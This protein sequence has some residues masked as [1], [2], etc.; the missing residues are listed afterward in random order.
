M[1]RR[2]YL[3]AVLLLSFTSVSVATFVAIQKTKP[4]T[5]AG[6]K[7]SDKTAKGAPAKGSAQSK[8]AAPATPIRPVDPNRAPQAS[9]DDALFTNEDFFGT[10]ASVARPYAVALERIGT[11]E[12]QYPK[13]ARLR[14]HSARLAEH[15]GQFDKAAVA[16]NQYADLKRRSPDSLRRLAHFYHNRAMHPEEVTALTELARA[17]P[18]TER[19][20][21][22]KQAAGLVR[23]Y[24][25]K[26]FK[27]A[28]FFAELVAADSSNLQPVKDYVQE[29]RLAQQGNDALAVLTQY[30]AKFPSDSG[31]FLKTRA[32]I[33]EDRGDRRAAEEVYSAA[34]DPNWSRKIS[35]DY[36]EL[37]RRFGRYRIA[38]RA[39]QDRV[40][41]GA[42]DLQTIARL[43]GFLAYEGN[44][45]QA[46]QVLKDLEA[47]RAG[48]TPANTSSGTTP[49][50]IRAA[51]WTGEELQQTAGMFASIGHFDQAS[52]YL[53]TLYLLGKL[54][55]ATA[56]REDALYRLFKVMIDAAGTPTR[57]G[58][59]D[60]SFYKDIAEIDRHPGFMNGVLSLILSNTSPAD[61]FATQEQAAAGYFNRAFAYRIFT[62]F[63]QEFAQSKYLGEMYL[64]VVS[65]FATMGEHKLAIEAGRE[66]QQKFLAS[67][68][69]V[70]V[71]LSIADSYVAL[72]D[73][74]NERAT[75]L[76]L[77]DR[78]AKSRPRG[79]ALIPSS[80]KRWAYII[81]PTI[82]TIFDKIKY[83]LEAYSDTYEP[84]S[85]KT[86]NSDDSESS[87][88]DEEYGSD[89]SSSTE[90][91]GATYSS[92]LERYVSS[93]A[94]DDKQ[95]ET[96]AFFWNE[97]RKY[98]KE[99][100]LYERFLRWL[101]QAQLINEQ[102]KAY[103]SAIR[104]FDSNTWY[105]RL[106]RWYV[107][108]K[109][110]RELQRYAR[111]LI[112][113]FDEEEIS[114]YLYR[115]GGYGATAAGDELNWDQKLAFDLYDYAHKRFPRNLFFVRGK[116]TYLWSAKSYAEWA[117]L[118]QQYYFA[119]RSIRDPYLAWLSKENQLRDKYQQARN[120]KGTDSSQSGT[121]TTPKN[122]AY[123]TFAADGALWLSHHDEAL[124][125]YRALN[126]FYPGEV[127]YG[128]RLADLTRSFGQTSDKLYEES[129]KA[130]ENLAAVYPANH[131]YRIKAGEVYAQLSD[132]KRAGQQW[133][134][135]T[136]LEPGERETYLEVA[137]VYWDYYQFDE[138]L[139]VFRELRTATGEPNLYAYRMG[140][141]Y[142]NKGDYD[143]AIAEYV[144]VLNEPGD[145]R[146]TVARRLSQ[147]ARR[148]GIEPKIVAAYNR[149]QTADQKDWQLA[150]GYATYLAE[151][152]RQADALA[153]IRSEVARS[154]D[155][156][157]LE[158]VRDLFRAILRPEDEQQVISR[159]SSAARDEREVMMYRL[160][161]ASFLERQG[162]VDDAL[163]IVDK[164]VSDYP[165]NVGVV[166][167]SAKFYW[168]AGVVD[169]ALDLYKR[170]LARAQ[171]ANRRTITL[172]LARRQFD[173]NRLNDAETTLRGYYDENRLDTEA[174]S[175][176]AKVL[177]AANKLDALTEL[178]K[179]ALK[180]VREAGGEDT[181]DRIAELRVG[182]I[183]TFDKLKRYED[184]VDQHIEIINLF[185]ENES[186]LATA[187]DYA[188]KH[189]L[190]PRLTAYYEKLTKEAFKNYRWQLVLAR[191]YERQGNIA[192]ASEQYKNAVANDPSRPEFRRSL[193]STLARQKRYD[194][195]IAVLRDG[196]NLSGRDPE[197]LIEV[198]Q[199]QISQGKR[200]DAVL[201][202]RQALT[203]R[204]NPTTDDDFKM[205][206]KLA[207]WGLHDEAVRV[208]EQTFARVPKVLK[209]EY[210]NGE[211]VRGYARSL[212]RIEPAGR[213]FQKLERMHE[214]YQ[215]IK[216][217]SKDND[218]Y[219]ANAIVENL[220]AALRADFGEGVIEYSRTEDI[221]ALV[222]A[223]QTATAKL[224]TYADKEE[225]LRYVGIAHGA[226]LIQLEEQLLT[227]IKDYA[228]K[229]R[230]K[231]EDMKC[232]EELRALIAF[233]NRRAQFAKAA[234]VLMAQMAEDKF[235]ARFDYQNQIALEYQLTGD[236][237]KELA[238]L[239]AAYAAASGALLE[240]SEVDWVER[241]FTLLVETNNRDELQRVASSFNPHQL[242]LVN[243]LIEKNDKDLA[244]TAIA[245]ASQSP[246]W[247]ASRSGEVGFFLK[248]TNPATEAYFKAAL[249]LRPIGQMLNR[250]LDATQ[251]LLGNDWFVAARNYG[252]WLSVA[253]RDSDSRKLAPAEIEG[254]PRSE[255]AQLE[256]AAYYLDRKDTRRAMNHLQIAAELKP[257]DNDVA[258][259]R[260]MVL[261]AQGDRPGALSAWAAMMSGRVTSDDA[262]AYL[263]VTAGNGFL[264]EGLPLLEDFIISFVNRPLRRGN[265]SD[266]IETIKP[267]IREI[268]NRANA[269]TQNAVAA[270]FSKIMNNTPNDMDIGLL[271]IDERLL[272]ESQLLPVYRAIHQKY[273]DA[274][275]ATFGTP[276]YEDGTTFNNSYIYPARDLSEWRRKFLDYLIRVSNLSE[277]RL[278]ITSIRREEKEA[279]VALESQSGDEESEP[280]D[281]YEWLPLAS[282]LVELRSGRNVAAAVKELREYCHLE[283]DNSST[284]SE[285]DEYSTASNTGIPQHCLKA[286]ALLVAEKRDAE[287]E[288]LLYDAYRKAS[289]T[290]DASDASLAGLAEIEARRGRTAEASR[291]LRKIVERSTDNQR[292]LRLAAETAAKIGRFEEA[293]EFRQQ[294]ARV[295]PDDAANQVEL[296]RALSVSGNNVEAVNLTIKL[297]SD[298]RTP[299]SAKAQLAEM[300]A[301]ITRADRVAGEKILGLFGGAAIQMEGGALLARAAFEENTGNLDAARTTLERVRGSL[302]PV[303]RLKL[304]VL[305]RNT[306]R[307]AEAISNFERAI[308]LDAEGKI[309]D[310]IEFRLANPRAQLI[311]LYSKV[312]R[313]Q[314]AIRLTEGESG[315]KSPLS[316]GARR[317][318]NATSSSDSE[319]EGDGGTATL[320]FEPSLN[321][322]RSRGASL[323]TLAELNEIAA[324]RMQGELLAALANSTE[325]LGKL[326]RAIALERLRV[327]EEKR[328]DEKATIEKRIAALLATL[329]AREAQT[330][331]LLRVNKSN[332]TQAIYLA[333]V[334]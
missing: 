124:D 151:S 266:R 9:V 161:Q 53:Y 32:A 303:A 43:F 60:L 77:L 39:L 325:R 216:A 291:L 120:R 175:E 226:G 142:E 171:G 180:D 169:R 40:K 91:K 110:G 181:K 257:G 24:A 20:P 66:F 111:Q 246:A 298:R 250:K 74:T 56:S 254:A 319:D 293:I 224:T 317:A 284:T 30:Q 117:K 283:G 23:T 242:Q 81:S 248:D 279:A 155:V 244:R 311:V 61:E 309:T 178:Y 202:M 72:K 164:L 44:D 78:L 331:N 118:S 306:N 131:E 239:S 35:G 268:A 299:N 95:Q 138:S 114:D 34:F 237:S 21:I 210:V 323:R 203:A 75:I 176:L 17:V 69:Y 140:A 305:A 50:P 154:S 260:G 147:L 249:D 312:Q 102:L 259:M 88:D 264:K 205:A 267:L 295:N 313:D 133:D 304:G 182:M 275:A 278:L 191:I 243:F 4:T 59:G 207:G 262:M 37:L 115:F 36:Y 196:W 220:N 186:R 6:Q 103:N 199:I 152:N 235:K 67:P 92:V 167:E 93:L 86:D 200:D 158:T 274:A 215:A 26:E 201:T 46:S 121:A 29:L 228:F 12:T 173:A 89:D 109:R 106:A 321:I 296:V 85:D 315:S 241:Y 38:R 273:A 288:A 54:Q 184:G 96:V 231:P 174:F 322:T 47:R 11:L 290:R 269:Q 80:S 183:E 297:Y 314:A 130:L 159:L 225:L 222:T 79:T 18:V 285:E 123:Q 16:M 281:Y 188:E 195:A 98:P 68:S 236:K 192:G 172:Q 211:S 146:D 287:A 119:D 307:D 122:F 251:N 149:T 328:T 107:R 27:P 165:T 289:L 160:Q 57:V 128:E 280:V 31:Y 132:F 318:L 204:K 112:D 261:L 148:Q 185:P 8:T 253:G 156:A 218:S 145:G 190:A 141:V 276:E 104:Q 129:A 137:T 157:F 100:G 144:K 19:A 58:T 5:K 41:A 170:T 51:V 7:S 230:Q 214:Q 150:I 217:N 320:V 310:A 223:I 135:L 1:R 15:L 62:S 197:W 73:R 13:D 83:N 209:D 116:L 316:A 143:A 33:L 324:S 238:A 99:E 221:G 90:K 10:S 166:E 87:G 2:I 212:I 125:A 22:Y 271:I 234:E 71:T 194:E 49:Q 302:E 3:A 55:P 333:R 52:R 64:G 219:R 70:D 282:A 255:D 308:Y 162:K 263:K 84:A 65:V 294:L 168:R 189:N 233:Y 326:E 227:R 63:K 206:A 270:S 139:R 153:L 265:Y 327:A 256:L 332:T 245:N 252:Y 229:A 193:A 198:A 277:A 14:L 300:V 45:E 126:T 208:Y 42:T 127:Q 48:R 330:A 187:L 113:V 240:S 94:T 25:L 108:Q 179:A 292:A 286:Y 334:L 76:P 101:G 301:E 28:D 213:V 329:R 97:I 163:A 105:H 136:K 272:P 247:V 134:T 177:G 232:Y 258:A 82:D